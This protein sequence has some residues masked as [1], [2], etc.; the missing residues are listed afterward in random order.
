M[1]Q[2]A[3][4]YMLNSRICLNNKSIIWITHIAENEITRNHRSYWRSFSPKFL[5]KSHQ[6]TEHQ[7]K[8]WW[9]ALLKIYSKIIIRELGNLKKPIKHT[10][11]HSRL[12]PWKF[13]KHNDLCKFEKYEKNLRAFWFKDPKAYK[14]HLKR[15]DQA[16]SKQSTFENKHR[17][18]VS[19]KWTSNV[20]KSIRFPWK[21]LV[22]HKLFRI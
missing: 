6:E 21:L 12:W 16:F 8:I 13:W 1:L 9:S 20:T 22:P 7:T 11:S 14:S 15:E 18:D 2:I 4:S 3:H 17:A 5:Q 10:K 19:F